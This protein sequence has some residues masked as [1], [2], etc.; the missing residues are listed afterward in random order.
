MIQPL[1]SRAARC[2]GCLNL[3][4]PTQKKARTTSAIVR[5]GGAISDDKKIYAF[6]PP[7]SPIA[8]KRANAPARDRELNEAGLSHRPLVE[9]HE[10]GSHVPSLPSQTA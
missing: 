9:G 5:K 3:S 10:G 7:A 1:R 2:V 4:C 8:R 6:C